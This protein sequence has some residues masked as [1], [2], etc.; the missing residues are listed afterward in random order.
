MIRFYRTGRKHQPSYKIVVA[1]KRRAAGAG[2]FTE[3]VGFYNPVTKEKVIR[4]DRVKHWISK[5]AQPSATVRNLLVK[6]K[7]I[8]GAKIPTHA[9]SKKKAEAP[10]QSQPAPSA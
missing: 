2:R 10:A 6:E 7:V 1:D 4:Q 5:G 9:K 8:A 3:E